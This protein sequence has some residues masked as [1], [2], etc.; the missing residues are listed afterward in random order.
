VQVLKLVH[1]S[2]LLDIETVGQNTICWSA[3]AERRERQAYRASS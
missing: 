1:G 2:E 3:Y